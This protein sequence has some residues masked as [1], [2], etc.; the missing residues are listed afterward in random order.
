MYPA[1]KTTHIE[2]VYTL[3]DARKI[4]YAED[5]RRR[6]KQKELSDRKKEMIFQKFLGICLLAIGIIGTLFLKDGTCLF[7]S[8]MGIVRIIY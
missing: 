2:T 8:L 5:R 6:A 3:E 7:V 4:I 1:I